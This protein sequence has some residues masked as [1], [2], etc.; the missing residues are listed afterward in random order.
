M[1][2]QQLEVS[3]D[4]SGISATGGTS[5]KKVI[6]KMRIMGIGLLFLAIGS[7]G[8]P[9]CIAIVP[10]AAQKIYP[11]NVTEYASLAVA[12]FG[13]GQMCTIFVGRY[14]DECTSSIGRRRPFIAGAVVLLILS[15]VFIWFGEAHILK[16]VCFASYFGLGFGSGWLDILVSAFA[17]DEIS[18]EQIGVTGGIFAGFNL[19]GMLLTFVF[20]LVVVG[21]STTPFYVYG[22]AVI[23]S[24]SVPYLFLGETPIP[25][26]PHAGTGLADKAWRIMT[27]PEERDYLKTLLVEEKFG[28]YFGYLR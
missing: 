25:T 19:L 26:A 5:G 15:V 17:N 27:R 10:I 1:G 8:I 28:K 2:Q 21:S 3:T 6:S 4:A 18:A 11:Q 16:L 13:L 23:V 20:I 24:L 22:L 9:L 7:L 14:S 12:F